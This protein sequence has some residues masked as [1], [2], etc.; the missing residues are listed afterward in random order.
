L[1]KPDDCSE[2]LEQFYLRQG[3]ENSWVEVK[4]SSNVSNPAGVPGGGKGLF[5]REVI[6]ADTYVCP[7]V[8]NI[9][10][11]ACPAEQDCAYCLCVDKSYYLCARDAKYDMGYLYGKHYSDEML[12]PYLMRNPYRYYNPV[13]VEAPC[14]PNYARYVNTLTEEQRK[15]KSF[16]CMFEGAL[17]GHYVIY[18]KTTKEIKRGDELLVDYGSAFKA[19]TYRSELDEARYAKDP[20]ALE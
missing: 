9:R 15:G 19:L 12:N 3:R 18:V 14:P 16:N 6:P 10:K 20:E 5:A 2:D 8:G 1:S 11:R 4:E 17:D 7:Y 13:T